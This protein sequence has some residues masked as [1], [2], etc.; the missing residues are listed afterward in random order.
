MIESHPDDA[1]ADLRVACPF[2]TLL[3]HARSINMAPLT[4][5]QHS[6]VPYAVILLQHLEHWRSTHDGGLPA[7]YADKGAFRTGLRAA[8][9][10]NGDGVAEHETN[11]EEAIKH[12]N[13]ALAP[14]C[15]PAEVQAILDHPRAL[16][17]DTQV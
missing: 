17:T 15:I 2:P 16:N 10:V 6:H 14:P 13:T 8:I 3:A 9:R 1:L 5:E 11:F 4:L 7:T 12:T